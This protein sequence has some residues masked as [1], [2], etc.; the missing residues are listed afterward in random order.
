MPDQV[1]LSH[2][3]PNE[4]FEETKGKVFYLIHGFNQAVYS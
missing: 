4:I 1:F 2:K 3:R